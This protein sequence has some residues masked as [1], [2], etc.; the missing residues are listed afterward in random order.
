MLT[1]GSA[2]QE[3]TCQDDLHVEEEVAWLALDAGTWF[4]DDGK[5][6]QVH[7]DILVPWAV[8]GAKEVG[9]GLVVA[10]WVDA[11]QY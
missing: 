8:Y 5:M 3:P 6:I 7:L 4:T 9:G 1:K 11:I 10:T 2:L